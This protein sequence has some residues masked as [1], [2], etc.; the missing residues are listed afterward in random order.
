V[1]RTVESEVPPAP[2]VYESGGL[3]RWISTVDHKE[4]GMLYMG[5]ALVFFLIGGIEALLM[6]IQLAQPNERFLTPE[7]Y[8]QMFT[9][10]GTTMVFLFGMPIL[11]GIANYIVPL[12]IGTYDMAFPR[13]NALGYWL[14]LF[15]ALL[16]NWSFLAGGAPDQMWF[17]YPPLTEVPYSLTPGP[18]FW[19]AGLLVT[20]IGT[21][22][23]GINFLVTILALRAPGLT[24]RRLSL[25]VWSIMVT[26]FLIIWALPPLAAAQVMLLGDRLIGTHFFDIVSGGS[27]LLW[28]HEFWSFGHPEVYILILPVFGMI[29]ETISVFSRKRLFGYDFLVGSLFAITFLAFIVWA[30][31]M[32]TSGLSPVAEAFFSAAS[33]L[34]A[35]PTGVKIFNWLG[36]MW[37]GT[38]RF[39]TSMLFAIGFIAEFV[40]GGLT[41]PMLGSVPVDWQVHDSYFIVAHLH[42]VLYGGT[43]MGF[44]AGAYYWFPKITGRLLNETLGKWHFWLTI[45]G[46][47]VTFFPMHFL[48]LLGMPRHFWTYGDFPDWGS[49]NL[50]ETIGSFVLAASIVILLANVIRSWR[51]GAIAGNDPWD[52]WTLEWATSSPPPPHNFD[53]VPVVRSRRPLW[54]VKHPDN[55]DPR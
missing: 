39:T 55:P 10:H 34:I 24:F 30:H 33:M 6:R 14:F 44:F 18:T 32:F 42:Y 2:E 25:F 35:V 47:N 45:I 29:S 38:L 11:I 51:H 54:D 1:A 53:V 50:T 23:T 46:V 28:E 41:G 17:M 52:A 26:S 22:A 36:T 16:V 15:G 12:Q 4:I 3:W 19:A 40:I 31:H 7:A 49:L 13:L 48:G 43:V 5:T 9:M 37:G 20:S 21:I 8:N 27:V